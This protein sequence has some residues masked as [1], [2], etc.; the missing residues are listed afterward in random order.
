MKI[1]SSACSFHKWNLTFPNFK[2]SNK[3]H[4]WWSINIFTTISCALKMEVSSLEICYMH[5]WAHTLRCI[6]QSISNSLKIFGSQ[7]LWKWNLSLQILYFKNLQPLEYRIM[8][9]TINY[10]GNFVHEIILIQWISRKF[11]RRSNL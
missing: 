5:V 7:T 4:L 11:F 9:I 8:K 10:E 6:S 3:H 1:C 2:Y